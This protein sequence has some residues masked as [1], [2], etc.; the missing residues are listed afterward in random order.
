MWFVVWAPRIKNPGYVLPKNICWVNRNGRAQAVVRVGT[1]PLA[2]NSIGTNW[3]AIATNISQHKVYRA[4]T[5]AIHI[6]TRHHKISNLEC[7]IS[8]KFYKH[9]LHYSLYMD[10]M[11][12]CNWKI[13][14]LGHVIDD[15]LCNLQRSQIINTPIFFAKTSCF[16]TIKKPFLNF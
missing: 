7:F 10:H 8:E 12:T 4:T 2:P 3:G 6:I 16:L 15:G 9:A 14:R 5:S 1:A 11:I 13:R